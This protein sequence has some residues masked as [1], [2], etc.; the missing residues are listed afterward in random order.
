MLSNC[1]EAKYAKVK[2][3]VKDG[4]KEEEFDC[5]LQ[6]NS[7]TKSWGGVDLAG[8]MANVYGLD[9]KYCKWWKKYFF[10]Y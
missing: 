8:K 5:P 1:H 7:T 3:T 4:S 9:R 6:S 10:A 2:R